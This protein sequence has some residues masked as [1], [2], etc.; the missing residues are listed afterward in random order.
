MKFFNL[1]GKASAGTRYT[2]I[3]IGRTEPKTDRIDPTAGLKAGDAELADFNAGSFDLRSGIADDHFGIADAQEAL[4]RYLLA[5]WFADDPSKPLSEDGLAVRRE[6][7]AAGPELISRMAVLF[8]DEGN[9]DGKGNQG[10]F[11]D[12][13]FWLT[14]ELTVVTE[15]ESIA[16]LVGRVVRQPMDIP[17]WL[18]W[19]TRA[20]GA[21]VKPGRAVR[22][23]LDRVLNRLDEYSYSRCTREMQVQLQQGLRFL[24]PKAAD[25]DKKSLFARILR[26]RIPGR[27]SWEQEWHALHHH[28][29]DGPEQ[30]QVALRDKWKEG[31]S[32][33]RIGYTALLDNLRPML[34]AGVSGKVLK[35]AA[36]YLGNAAAVRR[37]GVSPLQLLEVNQSLRRIDQGGAGMLSEALEE[38][39]LHSGWNRFGRTGTSLIAMDIS[40]SM[41]RPIRSGGGVQR[42]D[43]APLLAW[44]WRSKGYSVATGIIGNGWKPFD[45][46]ERPVLLATEQFRSREGEA[47]YGIN[48]HLILQDLLRRKQAVDRVLIFTDCRLWGSRGFNQPAGTD[49]SEW[50]RLYRRDVA[51]QAKL[52]LFDLAG[53]GAKPLESVGDDAFLIAGWKEGILDVLAAIED[54][55]AVSLIQ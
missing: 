48:A 21:G 13:A 24:Q 25:K 41:K 6:I 27:S 20:A 38:A 3:K 34:C 12:A 46:A 47:G 9:F 15:G 42:F 55:K 35:L 51:P 16:A 32:S 14:A 19:F 52:Y 37:S 44:L 54:R 40:N 17:R 11:R 53:Y 5:A 23:V 18:S 28:H 49:L 1:R 2:R 43:I 50:W 45:L 7:L 33:F 29:Y 36:E 30:R 31:I 39:V 26:D 4:Y 8:D 10:N 22:K